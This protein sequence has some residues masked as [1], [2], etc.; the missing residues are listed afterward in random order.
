M[1]LEDVLLTLAFKPLS[2]GNYAIQFIDVKTRLF[3]HTLYKSEI[4]CGT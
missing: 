1:Q 4:I 3:T 2:G